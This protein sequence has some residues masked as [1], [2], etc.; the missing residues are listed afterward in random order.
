M[1]IQ[2]MNQH[3]YLFYQLPVSTAFYCSSLKARIAR[4]MGLFSTFKSLYTCLYLSI[5]ILWN[6][7]NCILNY[8]YCITSELVVLLSFA[9]TAPP[10]LRTFSDSDTHKTA[11]PN[12]S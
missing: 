8:I 9:L 10:Y 6:I 5:R 2:A 12:E 4:A 7:R 1:M 3:L 11:T